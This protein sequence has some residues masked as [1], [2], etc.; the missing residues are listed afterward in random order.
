MAD[1]LY[2]ELDIDKDGMIA[3]EEFYKAH[4]LDAPHFDEEGEEH[5]EDIRDV[6]PG[7]EHSRQLKAWYSMQLMAAYTSSVRP[8]TLVA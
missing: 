1:D 3:F 5:P 6:H 4:Y 8:H 2:K 7:T